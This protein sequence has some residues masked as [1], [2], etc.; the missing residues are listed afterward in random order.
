MCMD[1]VIYLR[2]VTS[3]HEDDRKVSG[4]EN[5]FLMIFGT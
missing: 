1:V 4:K 3:F 2:Q 5:V